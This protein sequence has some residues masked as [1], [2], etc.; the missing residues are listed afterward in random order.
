MLL[1]RLRLST[2]LLILTLGTAA[3]A[4][5]LLVAMAVF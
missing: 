4:I 2:Q 3:V 5:I 1:A